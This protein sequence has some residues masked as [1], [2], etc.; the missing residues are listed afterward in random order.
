MEQ[1]NPQLYLFQK[2]PVLI[3]STDGPK[4]KVM[5][6]TEEILEEKGVD[7]K[8]NS[9]PKNEEKDVP[10]K[11]DEFV[12][13]HYII[14]SIEYTFEEGDNQM[15]QKLTLLRREWPLRANDI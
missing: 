15:G 10:H 5:E 12:S 14:S 11:L 7:V 13:G 8:D 2:I 6:K 1:F 4:T 3:Y 9:F